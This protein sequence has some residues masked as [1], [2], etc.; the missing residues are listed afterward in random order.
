MLELA[1][2]GRAKWTLNIFNLAENFI[3]IFVF[4]E[5]YLEFSIKSVT[6]SCFKD[7]LK[8]VLWNW[9]KELIKNRSGYFS[10]TSRS[11]FE[12]DVTGEAINNTTAGNICYCE[13]ARTRATATRN[14]LYSQYIVS[15]TR[16]TQETP[17][18]RQMTIIR[19]LV[20]Y[21]Q[22]LF[23]RQ[24]IFPTI[25]TFMRFI[26]IF[27]IFRNNL[28]GNNTLDGPCNRTAMRCDWSLSVLFTFIVWPASYQAS[29]ITTGTKAVNAEIHAAT[30]SILNC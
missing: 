1:F 11:G 18:S 28:D 24:A 25:S 2:N 19:K 5:I 9:E 12:C 15:V 27:V 4:D 7:Q 10:V 26:Q 14:I 13:G 23:P 20:L 8:I 6:I 3:P 30:N 16:V 29:E 22:A 21:E 17:A